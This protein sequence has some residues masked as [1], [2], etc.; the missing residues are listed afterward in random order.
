MAENRLFTRLAGLAECL[1]REIAE[2]PDLP[3][4]CFCGVVPG[5]AAISNYAGDC[6][7]V[8]GM[9]WVRLMGLFASTGV[10]EINALPGNCS[11][12]LS[13]VV[14]IGILRCIDNG[15]DQGNPPPPEEL[16]AAT[17][18]QV[19]DAL[20]MQRALVCCSDI[21]PKSWVL[22]SYSPTGPLGGIYGGTWQATVVV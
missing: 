4:P 18:L 13:A 1:C 6:G 3:E 15:D 12:E 16:L 2:D 21:D 22:G 8:C 17:D 9:A 19:R 11:G 7:D 5:D 14:E 10:T 20:A